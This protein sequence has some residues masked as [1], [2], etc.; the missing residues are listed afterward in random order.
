MTPETL[1]RLTAQSPSLIMGMGGK[2]ALTKAELA[3]VICKIDPD[4]QAWALYRYVGDEGVMHRLQYQAWVQ[5]AKVFA[6]YRWR[7]HEKKHGPLTRKLGLMALY[8][9]LHRKPCT[10][11]GGSRYEPAGGWCEACDGSGYRRDPVND[12]QRAQAIGMAYT[13]WVST[14]RARYILVRRQIGHWASE[15]DSRVWEGLRGQ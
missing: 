4:A 6:E 10:G 5:S 11:C 13:T 14:W 7:G 8:E 12:R 9:T 15:Q 1:A 2:P 3:G